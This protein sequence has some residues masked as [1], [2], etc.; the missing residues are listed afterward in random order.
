M[1]NV[2]LLESPGNNIIR[3]QPKSNSKAGKSGLIKKPQNFSF[4]E[5]IIKKGKL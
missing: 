5:V 2:G 3:S 4:K 1:Y